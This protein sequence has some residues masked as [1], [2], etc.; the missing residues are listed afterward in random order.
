ML[1]VHLEYGD[2]VVRTVRLSDAA[3]LDRQLRDNRA[4]L[5]KWEA[6]LPGTS[7]LPRTRDVIRT[8]RSMA[9]DNQVVPCVIVVDGVLVGQITLSGMSY[10]SLAS[11]AIGYWVSQDVAGRG[12]APTAVAMLTDWSF[13]SGSLHRVEI[14]IRPENAASLRVVQKLGF[15]YEGL[16]RRYI[17]IDGD[18]R[19]HF[20]FAVTYDESVSGVLNKFLRGRVNE[21]NADIPEVDRI[22]AR[23]PLRLQ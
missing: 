11:G 23:T 16:R 22:A 7:G 10:G 20:T 12:I 14:A 15:R 5:Q 6:T 8:L 1:G 9:R 19:D 18:W 2:I 21:R 13:T 4:W 3:Q 17:H